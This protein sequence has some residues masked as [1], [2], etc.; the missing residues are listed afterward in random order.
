MVGVTRFELATSRPPA[1]RAT[2]LRHTPRCLLIPKAPGHNLDVDV[3][4]VNARWVLSN[5]FHGSESFELPIKYDIQENHMRLGM[6]WDTLYYITPTFRKV[7][8]YD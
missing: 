7:Q 4:R 5:R 6:P 8:I 1:V 2:E 3:P